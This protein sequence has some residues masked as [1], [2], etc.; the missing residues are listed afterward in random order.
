MNTRGAIKIA[1]ALVASAALAGFVAVPS[2][3]EPTASI[4]EITKDAS[5]AMAQDTYLQ[6]IRALLAG[7]PGDA[8]S[9]ADLIAGGKSICA[10]IDAGATYATFESQMDEYKLNRAVYRVI[11]RSSVLTFCPEDS[12][13]L[14]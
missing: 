6:T 9:D 14:P 2:S 4:R 11:I 13:I 1:A 12:G 10:D 3:A 5:P 8:Q 7:K